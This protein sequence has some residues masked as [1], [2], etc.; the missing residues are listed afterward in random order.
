LRQI[1]GVLPR[2]RATFSMARTT[3]C[4]ACACESTRSKA[5]SASVAST[6]PAGAEILG[7]EILT[8][9]L[10]QVGIDVAGIDAVALAV[11]IHVLEQFL[12]RQLPHLADD[13]RRD[14]AA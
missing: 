10:A 13:A 14:R 2:R 5:C 9:R 4:L 7:T 12:P 8:R 6:V 11:V 1:E 3:F